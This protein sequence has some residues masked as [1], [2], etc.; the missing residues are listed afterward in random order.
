MD[1]KEFN[2]GDDLA[3]ERSNPLANTMLQIYDASDVGYVVWNDQVPGSKGIP[4]RTPHAHSKGVMG[5]DSSGG[6]YLQHSTP[7]FPDDPVKGAHKSSGEYTGIQTPQLKLGQSY[8]CMSLDTDNLNTVA[9]VVAGEGVIVF[10]S[11]MAGISNLPDVKAITDGPG[12]SVAIAPFTTR[13]GEAFKMYGMPSG[14]PAY[15]FEGII[16]PD[17]QAG[18]MVQTFTEGCRFHSYC[19]G[20]CQPSN[21]SFDYD[22]L[23]VEKIEIPHTN[24]AWQAEKAPGTTK[25][26]GDEDHSKWAISLVPGKA[27]CMAD[28]NRADT[29]LLDGGGA[30][31]FTD[32]MKI[33]TLFNS[34]VAM[35][36]Q[37]EVTCP[38]YPPTKSGAEKV[39]TGEPPLDPDMDDANV[40]R[41][42]GMGL[43]S[44]A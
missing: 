43:S 42:S 7:R 24:F 37:C 1:L 10:G 2:Q 39:C 12:P 35:T 27:V 22:T 31:C 33:W 18:L 25:G 41:S 4:P 29:Q 16:E 26:P 17:I 21:Y 8:L 5:F 20:Q 13:G 3:S 36:E 40:D 14:I 34:I 28:N 6:F 11:E 23:N 15:I 30:A 32:N 19:P 44:F 9:Q 38:P